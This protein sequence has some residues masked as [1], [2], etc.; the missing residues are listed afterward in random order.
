M[1]M[2]LHRVR[3]VFLFQCYTGLRYSD[4]ANLRRCDVHEKYI[5]ITTI[6]TIDSLRIELNSHSRAILKKYELFNFKKGMALP[7]VSNQKMNDYLFK[8][9]KFCVHQWSLFHDT[10]SSTL[11]DKL[12]DF[13]GQTRRLCWTNS[14]SDDK[15]ITW[16]K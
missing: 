6:K 11:L 4:L 13:V 1:K 2:Y 15:K 7:V 14:L 3:D 9:R 8:F 12:V 16:Y 5:E 10:N